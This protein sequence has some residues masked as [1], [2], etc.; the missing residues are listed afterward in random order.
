MI[1]FDNSVILVLNGRE[2]YKFYRDILG[3]EIIYNFA[4]LEKN[5]D[6]IFGVKVFKIFVEDS[7][8]IIFIKNLE[9]D[10]VECNL[11]EK[12]VEFKV[13]KTKDEKIIFLKDLEGHNLQI[14]E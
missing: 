13:K 11:I 8:F 4:E 5:E 3:K 7:R 10:K 12:N 9:I 14:I 6:Y 1:K 2:E